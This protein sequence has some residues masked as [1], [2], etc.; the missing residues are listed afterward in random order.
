MSCPV[1]SQRPVYPGQDSP[2]PSCS[3]ESRND[4][5]VTPVQTGWVRNDPDEQIASTPHG[6]AGITEPDSLIKR[7]PSSGNCPGRELMRMKLYE[8]WADRGYVTR[9]GTVR[10]ERITAAYHAAQDELRE[11]EVLRGVVELTPEQAALAEAVD[12]IA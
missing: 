3:D 5:P 2:P 12:V 1:S 7:P 10:A 9:V 8:Y 6:I 4:A 11:G